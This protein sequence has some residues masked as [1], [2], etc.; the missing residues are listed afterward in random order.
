MPHTHSATAAV[1]RR[2][3]AIDRNYIKPKPFG[4]KYVLVEDAV[5][6]RIRVMAAGLSATRKVELETGVHR[7]KV[8][9]L[10]V[11]ARPI[12][13]DVVA[14]Q[15]LKAS[16]AAN[17]AKHRSFVAPRAQPK[18][19]DRHYPPL[20]GRGSA[21][22]SDKELLAQAEPKIIDLLRP[23]VFASLEYS[24]APSP[25]SLSSVCPSDACA[26]SDLNVDEPLTCDFGAQCDLSPSPSP[27]GAGVADL[28]KIIRHFQ[29]LTDAQNNSIAALSWACSTL[30]V[31]QTCNFGSK[32][33]DV[34]PDR[35][36]CDMY[37]MGPA[38]FALN[39]FAVEFAP[40]VNKANSEIDRVSSTDPLAGDVN[41]DTQVSEAD[42]Q[43]CT[44]LAMRK[45]EHDVSDLKIKMLEQ[46]E[47][48]HQLAAAVASLEKRL[49]DVSTF[50]MEEVPAKLARMFKLMECFEK[51]GDAMS[52]HVNALEVQTGASRA[53][54]RDLIARL[55]AMCEDLS[56]H[57]KALEVQAVKLRDDDRDL[58]SRL[59]ALEDLLPDALPLDC[60]LDES[61]A[62]PPV[63]DS[64]CS[65]GL[66]QLGARVALVG[67]QSSMLNGTQG[68]VMEMGP[69]GNS[70]R[71]GVL[72]DGG[73][74]SK[75]I[76]LA[77][78]VVLPDDLQPSPL[79]CDVRPSSRSAAGGAVKPPSGGGNSVKLRR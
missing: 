31:W 64:G 43:G 75:A 21:T 58:A 61:V 79:C 2:L 7:R 22:T 76:K 36:S 39:P 19:T 13:G 37:S 27:F 77:N 52:E 51:K 44:P 50:V 23:E 25:C 53:D 38:D 59:V 41:K 6:P 63:V 34:A 45:I 32:D 54:D 62:A 30:C 78:L 57:V 69:G 5:A 55:V 65:P 49:T 1:V 18:N 29:D 42:S 35:P 71:A 8:P 66:L 12:V 60:G 67:L 33:V 73:A 40:V 24:A 48:E 56:V 9:E 17:V 14:D 46:K 20:P 26:T 10:A 68:T 28:Q 11:V 15:L 70:D 47:G 3:R 72:L 16:T 4:C 74:V